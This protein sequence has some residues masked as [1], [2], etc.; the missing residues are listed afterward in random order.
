MNRITGLETLIN[1]LIAEQDFDKKPERLYAPIDYVMSQK[2]KR[3]RPILALLACELFQGNIDDVKYPALAMEMFHNF[4]LVHDDIM[5]KAPLRRGFETVYKKWNSD[6]AILSGDTMFA[7]AYQ[8]AMKT[9]P[10]YIKGVLETL[11]KVAIEV[12][13][14]QQM[15]MDFEESDM[16]EIEDYVRM[17]TLKTAVLLGSSLK[18]GALI[19][20][21]SPNDIEEIYNFG[22]DFGIAFQL[23]DDLLDAYGDQS[24][25]GK[26]LGGDIR[27]NKKTYLYLKALQLA[28]KDQSQKLKA[29]FTVDNHANSNQKVKE[30]MAIFDQVNVKKHTIDAMQTYYEKSLVHLESIRVASERKK[31]LQF[32]IESL[33]SRNR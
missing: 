14:G 29:L 19:A 25:F 28:D 7:I 21:A 15:D 22:L 16:V 18:I 27:S 2:G 31:D 32:F 6:I 10:R 23:Q 4:T 9:Q 5:D 30:V 1:I 17:I 12:C 8:Y 13:E 3:I 33:Y 24:V 26:Q 20:E 11:S